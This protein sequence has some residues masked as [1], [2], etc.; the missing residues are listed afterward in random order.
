MAYNNKKN[1]DNVIS[2]AVLV[3]LIGLLNNK[4]Q[5]S[6]ILSNEEIDIIELPWWPN[7]AGDQRFMQ[8]FFEEWSECLPKKSPGNFDVIPRGIVTPTGESIDSGSLTNRFVRGKRIKEIDG[9]LH[10]INSYLNSIPLIYNYDCEIKTDTRLDAMKIVQ[11]IREVFFSTQVFYTS[12][13]GFK[14][15]CQVGFPE[16]YTTDNTFEYKYGDDNEITIEF[17]LQLE[18]Y[19]PVTDKTTDRFDN[20]RMTGGIKQKIDGI[21]SN[22]DKKKKIQI[23]NPLKDEEINSGST[24]NIKWASVG[25][26]SNVD[27]YYSENGEMWFPIVKNIKNVGEYNWDLEKHNFKNVYPV[28][29]E[30]IENPAKINFFV[31]GNGQIYDFEIIVPGIGYTNELEIL[32]EGIGH[33]GDLAEIEPIIQNGKLV[34]IKIK[35]GGSGYKPNIQS[36]IEIKVL[37]REFEIEDIVKNITVL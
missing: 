20:D 9:K 15:P 6:N 33:N 29:S 37:N 30:I 2:R 28:F 18:T 14:I 11:T 3:G 16:D 31:D 19:Q 5:Y 12:Y 35:Y 1:T 24:I 26:F 34:D 23:L 10:T 7:Q 27:I 13:N 21:T 17:Q 25:T 22:I 8:N 36:E 4:V 32:A